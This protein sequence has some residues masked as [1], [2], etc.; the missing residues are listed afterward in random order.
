MIPAYQP[1]YI[2]PLLLWVISGILGL[3]LIIFSKN[4]TKYF[5][6][7]F[8]YNWPASTSSNNKEKFKQ[9]DTEKR[10]LWFKRSI[11]IFGIILLS[12]PLVWLLLLLIFV[13]HMKLN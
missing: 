2:F 11:V 8:I 3:S 5:Y 9:I 7:T 10:G 12:F 4:I 6:E 1:T 13:L